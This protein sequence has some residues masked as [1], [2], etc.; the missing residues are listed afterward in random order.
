[1]TTEE[2]NQRKPKSCFLSVSCQTLCEHVEAS[3]LT[4]QE[5]LS[6]GRLLNMNMSHIVKTRVTEGWGRWVQ[7]ELVS[8]HSA[9]VLQAAAHISITSVLEAESNGHSHSELFQWRQRV[10][11]LSGVISDHWL[12]VKMPMWELDVGWLE[13]SSAAV[14]LHVSRWAKEHCTGCKITLYP[15]CGGHLCFGQGEPIPWMQCDRTQCSSS[16]FNFFV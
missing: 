5:D 4:R 16:G 1:M 8:T 14:S 11:L 15:R 10:S 7:D 13:H 6:G 3:F 12:R 2:R 9:R